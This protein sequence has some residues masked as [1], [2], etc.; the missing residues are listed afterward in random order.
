MTAPRCL[1]ILPFHSSGNPSDVF[2]ARACFVARISISQQQLWPTV[3]AIEEQDDRFHSGQYDSIASLLGKRTMP[4][5]AFA[6]CG[7]RVTIV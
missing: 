6:K 2:V 4:H 1:I 3:S 5:F 7:I